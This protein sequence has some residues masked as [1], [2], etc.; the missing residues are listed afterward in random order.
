MVRDSRFISALHLRTEMICA[1]FRRLSVRSIVNRLLAASYRAMRSTG[2]L[3][4]TLDHRRCRSVWGK[5][6]ECGTSVTGGTMPSQ[7]V[8]SGKSRFMLF[9]SDGRACVRL[10]QGKRL[11][12][13]CIKPTDS[14]HS[15]S[16][17]VW[18]AKH[19]RGRRKLVE[20]VVPD[21]TLNCQ[22]YIR[23]FR[24]SMLPW[25]TG[26]F[27]RNFV[28]VQDNATPHT[29]HDMRDFRSQQGV[30]VMDW[31]AWSPDMNP[32]E[33]VWDQMGVWIQD[34]DGPLP[35]YQNC[36]VLS[37]TRGLSWHHYLNVM[38]LHCGVAVTLFCIILPV[39]EP[40]L[41]W[42]PTILSTVEVMHIKIVS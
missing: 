33:H 3:R 5:R 21:G 16:V 37:S 25:A 1:F 32:I 13:A 9:H 14:N 31:R 18:G 30:K 42:G 20:L 23:I 15:P 28:Y 41:H 17:M 11:P 27:S 40:I 7:G 35:M 8:F 26:V 12:D 36:C 6:A 4:L 2:Y 22:C 39:A 29:A 24:D 10:R 19:H 38:F 34:M